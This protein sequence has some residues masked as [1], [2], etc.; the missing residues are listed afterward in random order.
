MENLTRKVESKISKVLPENFGSLL[1]GWSDIG[2]STH[3]M[4]IYAIFATD[5]PLLAFSPLENEEAYTA[6][7]QAE[8]IHSTLAIFQK[9][10]R[11]IVFMVSDNE[12][13]NARMA[14]DM[15]I[16][17]V[18]CYSHKLN[19]AVQKFLEPFG[20]TLGKIQYLMLKLKQLKKPA[21]L[22]RPSQLSTIRLNDTKWSST[23]NMLNRYCELKDFIDVSDTD[24][25]PHLVLPKP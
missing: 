6:Q 17:F 24:L 13:K 7:S 4:A 18:G 12:P 23:F 1:D 14:S 21:A 16:Y 10:I 22:R 19:L 2:T 9:D 20:G 3:Y 8:F 11:N 5:L 25:A 15:G